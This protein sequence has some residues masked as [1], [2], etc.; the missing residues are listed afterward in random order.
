[1]RRGEIEAKKLTQI[2]I[3]EKITPVSVK[4]SPDDVDWSTF[5]DENSSSEESDHSLNV[6]QDTKKRKGI[7]DLG[8]N[9]NTSDN[10]KK[11]K[12][13]M[14]E[15]TS[16]LIK[17]TPAK[18]TTNKLEKDRTPP[19]HFVS[20]SNLKNSTL[21]NLVTSIKPKISVPKLNTANNREVQ[22]E[23]SE[24]SEYLDTNQHVEESES[25][26]EYITWYEDGP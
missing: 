24:W 23:M 10:K 6:E 26:E 12:V 2:E 18:V 8:K 15:N 14:G 19:S 1:M 3:P 13:G 21:Q 20:N 16:N 4:E 5:L 17:N 11:Q 9:I 25:S 7:H 22:N